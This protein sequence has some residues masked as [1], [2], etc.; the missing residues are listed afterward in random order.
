MGC[1]STGDD[2][3]TAFLDGIGR[4]P[5]GAD[6]I[7]EDGAPAALPP[8]DGPVLGSD[9]KG[10]K[11][12][13]IGDSIFAGTAA[14]YGNDMCRALVPLGWRVAVEAEANRQIRFGRDVLSERLSEGWDAA[15]V[16][17]G[18][19]FNGNFPDYEYDLDRIVSSLA[20]RPTL[21]L[22]TSLFRPVQQQI[23]D[24]IRRVGSKYENVRILDWTAIS[25]IEGVLSPDKVHPSADGRAVLAQAISQA[26][27]VAPTSP[28][29]CLEAVFTDDQLD[30]VAPQ[31]TLAPATDPDPGATPTQVTTTTLSSST[32][33]PTTISSTPVPSS[34]VS[35]S[36]S[37]V[38]SGTFQPIPQQVTA[39]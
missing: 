4:L 5:G 14:R 16:F 36:G 7:G 30:D 29:A 35:P 15:V 12:L 32:V 2:D 13:M 17:L 24:V 19:N 6:A 28:G 11:L 37:V 21:L 8:F 26:S 38:S 20:P 27:G 25:A 10:N 33:P 31:D 39:N 23:N 34:T 3:M 1:S 22:T 9:A 18:T